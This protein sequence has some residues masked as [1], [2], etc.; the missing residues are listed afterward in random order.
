MRKSDHSQDP[1]KQ[2]T[3]K[4]IIKMSLNRRKIWKPRQH[5][6]SSTDLEGVLREMKL[7]ISLQIKYLTVFHLKN[8]KLSVN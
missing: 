4:I 7:E 3:T 8:T 1:N 5:F 6:S 2:I